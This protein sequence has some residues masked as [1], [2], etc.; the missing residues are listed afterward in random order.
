MNKKIIYGLSALA[1]I[2][3]LVFLILHA[4]NGGVTTPSIIIPSPSSTLTDSESGDGTIRLEVSPETVQEL[5]RLIE[6]VKTYSRGYQLWTYWEGGEAEARISVWRREN[7]F[8]V[9]HRQ[10]DVG[11]NTLILD[12]NVH[13]W[14]EG[15]DNVFSSKLSEAGDD[16][17]DE[18]ARL[19]TLDELMGLAPEDVLEA[20]FEESDGE[21]CIYV[22]YKSGTDRVYR[23]HVSA[24]RGLL[25]S[26][27]V[28]ENDRLI[29]KLQSILTDD[30]IP[31]EELFELP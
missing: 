27:E 21:N 17:L 2:L 7:S 18:F 5:I 8:R 22:A 31:S 12:N 25:I 16:A 9:L 15:S 3:I 30:T 24:E 10:N 26:G 28:L 20:G 19:I 14:Y 6:P 13:Y 1:L 4:V 23:L 11:K 29:Y